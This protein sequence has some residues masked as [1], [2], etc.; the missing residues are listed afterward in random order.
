MAE[1]SKRDV[2]GILPVLRG[3]I[4]ELCVGSGMLTEHVPQTYSRY[5]GLDLSRSL[6]RTLRQKI[7][8]LHL[9]NGDAEKPS[10]AGAS[11]DAILVFAGLHHLTNYE[12]AI[13]NA[14]G[15]LRPGGVFICLE[16]SRDA[17]YRKPM[18]LL[19]DFI[20]IY[21]KDEV[22]LDSRR[23]VGAMRATGFA[24]LRLRFLTP[25]FSPAFLS[26]RNRILV[27]FLYAAASLGN[28]ALTQSFFLLQGTKN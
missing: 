6:L 24:D 1:V 27:Q 21:S 17:W 2:I 11:F 20:G 26:P 7:P 28:G 9:V 4:L 15:M 18:E 8:H 16:P 22:F 5:Y 13:G 14:Y 23:V 10:F 12:A 25:R 19:R 3:E